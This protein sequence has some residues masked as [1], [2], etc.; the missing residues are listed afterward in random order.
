MPRPSQQIDQ[1][2]LASG[3]ILLPQLGCA[4]LS[5]R[6]L[7]EHAGTAPGMFHYHFESKEQFLRM[8]LAGVYEEMFAALVQQAAID[9][10]AVDRLRAALTA[11]ARFGRSQRLLIGRLWAD[12]AAGETAAREFFQHNAPRHIGVLMG[13]LTQGQANGAIKPLPP[14][15]AFA[16]LLGAVA[17]PS[18]FVAG[19]V[20]AGLAPPGGRAA[21]EA[22]VM[23]DAAIDLRIDLALAALSTSPE[24]A[25]P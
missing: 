17:L 11:L 24:S 23:S 16:F 5:V 21:F 9:G 18:I 8:L 12:A 22:Q 1:A 20:D 15:S 3:R 6:A 4:G 25:R 10:S 7:A 19:L 13:L 2:L 14:L